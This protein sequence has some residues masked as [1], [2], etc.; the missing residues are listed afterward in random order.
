MM[1]LPFKMLKVMGEPAD[2]KSEQQTQTKQI[3]STSL[4]LKLWFLPFKICDLN[5]KNHRKLRIL[6][7]R[8]ACFLIKLSYA[9]IY[10]YLLFINLL[11]FTL[12]RMRNASKQ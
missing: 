1:R 11:R 5:Y 3:M 4:P 2:S 12:Y 10:F 8:V 7:E 9:K 6:L